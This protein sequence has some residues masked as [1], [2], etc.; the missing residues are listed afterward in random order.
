MGVLKLICP[1]RISDYWI[2]VHFVIQTLFGNLMSFASNL[3]LAWVCTWQDRPAFTAGLQQQLAKVQG[4]WGLHD[5]GD[6][7]RCR[8]LHLRVWIGIP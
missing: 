6:V 4:T 5:G 8:C 2:G 7:F 1:N 3:S